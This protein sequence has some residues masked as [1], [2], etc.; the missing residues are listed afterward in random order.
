MRTARSS[1]RM[2]G[3][4]PLSVL[5]IGVLLLCHGVFGAQHLIAYDPPVPASHAEVSQLP[6]GMGDAPHGEQPPDHHLLGVGYLAVLL[7]VLLGLV[8]R[9]LLRGFQTWTRVPVAQ[10]FEPPFL[11]YTPHLPRGPTVPLLQIFRL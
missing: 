7:T 4:W 6:M 9:A 2:P 10:A 1:H 5:L 11:G 8:P 3:L